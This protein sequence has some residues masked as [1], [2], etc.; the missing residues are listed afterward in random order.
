VEILDRCSGAG[1]TWKGERGLDSARPQR[2]PTNPACSGLSWPGPGGAGRH[3]PQRFPQWICLR[4]RRMRAGVCR[5]TPAAARDPR[6]LLWNRR[7]WLLGLVSA[8]LALA[9]LLRWQQQTGEQ[10]FWRQLQPVRAEVEQLEQQ[11]N[12]EKAAIDATGKANGGAGRG[13]GDLAL[14]HRPDDRTWPRRSSTACS[15]LASR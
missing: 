15:S 1:W 8:C 2:T 6:R 10:R 5:L 3:D 12:R 13:A 9:L 11:L 14:R 4:E 7:A